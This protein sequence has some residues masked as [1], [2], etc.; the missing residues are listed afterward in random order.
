ME[1]PRNEEE[2]NPKLTRRKVLEGAGI[3]AG[4]VALGVAPIPQ[5]AV[6]RVSD[7]APG[8]ILDTEAR[9]VIELLTRSG[10]MEIDGRSSRVVIFSDRTRRQQ[11]LDISAKNT[12]T[13]RVMTSK[14]ESQ[15]TLQTIS[16][17]AILKSFK[18][19][20]KLGGSLVVE[21]GQH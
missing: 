14:N 16:G 7:A 4:T 18:V 5:S 12:E 1:Q 13:L 8:L 6:N 21:T 19:I 15:L 9:G 20:R 11:I 10:E 17:D 3:L 2:A